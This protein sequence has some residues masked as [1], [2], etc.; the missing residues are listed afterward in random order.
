MLL[1]PF[2]HPVP[3]RGKKG[4]Q[5]HFESESHQP[6]HVRFQLHVYVL[7]SNVFKYNL[8]PYHNT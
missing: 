7:V 1:V 4:Y 6:K 2:P 5:L 3:G 8:K